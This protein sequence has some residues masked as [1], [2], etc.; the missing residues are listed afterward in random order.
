[1]A[2]PGFY[3]TPTSGFRLFFNNLP[4]FIWEM[5][6]VKRVLT[7]SGI[8]K[9]YNEKGNTDSNVTAADIDKI[10]SLQKEAQHG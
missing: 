10:V 1:M 2:K 4:S 6:D 5:I 3:P 7:I 8:E 9:Y